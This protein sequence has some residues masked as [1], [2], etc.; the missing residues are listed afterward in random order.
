MLYPDFSNF[1][2]DGHGFLGTK[3]ISIAVF[4]LNCAEMGLDERTF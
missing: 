4:V 1:S 2:K 3:S